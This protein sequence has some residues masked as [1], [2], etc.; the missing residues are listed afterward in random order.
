MDW[1]DQ[2][3]L[4]NRYQL[5]QTLAAL[6]K[7]TNAA[8]VTNSGSSDATLTTTGTSTFAG[9]IQNGVTN[10]TALKV[11]GGDLT[12]SGMNTYTGDTTVSSESLRISNAALADTAD[13][14]LSTGVILDLTFAGTDTIDELY[15]NG[16]AQA[17]GTWGAF[18]SGAAHESP[19]I[20]GTGLLS[21]TT[22]GGE[23]RLIRLGPLPR[24][25]TGANNGATQD[26]ENDGIGNALEFVLGANPLASETGK[27]PVLNSDASN[28]IFTSSR[29]DE[30][31]AEIGLTFQ[32]GPTLAGWTD[33]P[34]AASN[35]STPPSSV[36]VTENAASPDTVVVTVPKTS[37]VG[38]KLFGRL[39]AAK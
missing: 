31:E 16:I 29:A 28:F 6:T 25:S 20:T 14:R 32:Y 21:V 18:G 9:V 38:G 3:G 26:P 17:T 27:L 33:V 37:A 36:A 34:V 2:P 12:L 5:G 35:S 39:K 4:G 10:R 15:I 1:H 30:S 7:N 19:L 24:G 22:A 8:T 23:A 11:T 13:V